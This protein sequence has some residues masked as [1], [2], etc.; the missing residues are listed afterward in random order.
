MA[1]RSEGWS[2]IG[3]C[4]NVDELEFGGQRVEG[5]KLRCELWFNYCSWK[6]HEFVHGNGE[7]E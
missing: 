6:Y 1:L 4:K 7:K 3:C 5:L 2:T